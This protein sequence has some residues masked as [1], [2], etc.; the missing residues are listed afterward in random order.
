M[1]RIGNIIKIVHAATQCRAMWVLGPTPETLHLTTSW[2][3]S[4]WLLRYSGKLA[5]FFPP[6]AIIITLLFKHKRVYKY[7]NYLTAMWPANVLLSKWQCFRACTLRWLHQKKSLN[8]TIFTVRN[9]HSHSRSLTWGKS[10][11][12]GGSLQ[13]ILLVIFF[14][15]PFPD[16][17]LVYLDFCLKWLWIFPLKHIIGKYQEFPWE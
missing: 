3:L 6:C 13:V 14:F 7:I 2:L 1:Q 4:L 17:R 15:F 11:Y 9:L 16:K 10:T 5:F 12:L 8:R